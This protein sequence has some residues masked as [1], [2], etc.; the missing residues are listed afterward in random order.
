MWFLH[1]TQKVAKIS[2][3]FQLNFKNIVNVDISEPETS[4]VYDKKRPKKMST[5]R[6]FCLTHAKRCH[7]QTIDIF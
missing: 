5:V 2:E 7:S 1:I 6:G 4:K 3:Y